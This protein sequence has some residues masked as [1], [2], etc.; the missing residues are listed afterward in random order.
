MANIT[1]KVAQIRAAAKGKDIRETMASGIETINTE[2]ESTTARQTVVENKQNAVEVRQNAVDSNES[3]RQANESTRQANESTR[4]TVYDEFRNIVNTSTEI[5]RVP[6]L[7]DGG[8][9]GDSTTPVLTLD[10]GDF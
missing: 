4:Q 5:N 10:G 2:V 9:F 7:F 8:D 6:Y 3:T 1:D